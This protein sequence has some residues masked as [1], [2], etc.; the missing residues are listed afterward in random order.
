MYSPSTL[1]VW[2]RESKKNIFT[3]HLEL[4]VTRIYDT[5]IGK[6]TVGT[7]RKKHELIVKIGVFF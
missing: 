3:T 1:S 7:K 5:N 4:K 6:N 2:V